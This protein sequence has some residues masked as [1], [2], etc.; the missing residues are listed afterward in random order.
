[1]ETLIGGFTPLEILLISTLASVVGGMVILANWF[2]SYLI[3]TNDE[4]SEEIKASVQVQT[5]LKGVIDTT[6]FLIQQLPGQLTDKIKATIK[7]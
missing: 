4:R 7:E 5:Q 6:N 1:M 2:Y 3:K